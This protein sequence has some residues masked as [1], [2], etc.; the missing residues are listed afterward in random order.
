MLSWLN[1]TDER[2]P[3]PLSCAPLPPTPSCDVATCWRM[4]SLLPSTSGVFMMLRMVKTEALL[5]SPSSCPQ[6]WT[7]CSFVPP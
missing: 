7:F 1:H 5:Q 3:L 2:L 6:D 4:V